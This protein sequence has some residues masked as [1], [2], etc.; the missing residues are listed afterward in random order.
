MIWKIPI[1]IKAVNDFSKNTMLEYLNIEFTD[2][3]DNTITATM[4][5][6]K[7]TYQ[8]FG[9]L[10][11]GASVVLAESVGSVAANLTIDMSK[12]AA[13][14]IEINANHIKAV[15]SGLVKAVGEPLHMGAT[16]QVWS[17]KIYDEK[18]ALVC[19]SRLTVALRKK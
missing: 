6:N 1:D 12:T 18:E 5:V 7:N 19:V 11:G 15:K 17:L 13:F 2:F 16:T 14:G 8:P 4:P 9:Y 3:T 10:H